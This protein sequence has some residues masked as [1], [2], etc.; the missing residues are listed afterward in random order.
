MPLISEYLDVIAAAPD[1]DRVRQACVRFLLQARGWTEFVVGF[2]SVGSR[3]R[4]LYTRCVPPSTHYVRELDRSVSYQ[5]DLTS[6][7]ASYLRELGQS[8][9]RSVWNLRRRLEGYGTVRLEQL[10]ADEV[11]SGFE[12]LN[13][14]HERRWRKV[15]FG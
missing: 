12:D 11:E 15:A 5:A 8:T 7:F 6:G 10:S 1:L 9:R 14:L 13:R 3:W 4:D 2:T